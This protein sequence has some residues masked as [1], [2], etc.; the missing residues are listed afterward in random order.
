MS[1]GIIKY[2]AEGEF[3][4]KVDAMTKKESVNLKIKYHKKTSE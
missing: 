1:L 2:S 3:V 4:K